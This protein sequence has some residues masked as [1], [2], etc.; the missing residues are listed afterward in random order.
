MASV[1]DRVEQV[2]ENISRVCQRVGRN[3]EEVTLVA[4]TK[5]V[6]PPAITEAIAA[7][8]KHIG[9]NR[10]QDAEQ[11]FTALGEDIRHVTRH[12]IGHLQT[13]KVKTAVEIF[14]VI[15]SVDSEKLLIEIEKRT[16][17]Q[18]RSSFD[19]LIEVNSGEEQKS[20]VAPVELNALLEKAAGCAHIQVKGLMTMAPLTDDKKQVRQAFRD[21]R[22]LR[23]KAAA[24]F[25]GHPRIDLHYLSMGMSSDYETAIEEGSNMVRIGSAI[26]RD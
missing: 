12:M 26:F 11:H 18:G 15:Q 20:G 9:E 13:N 17:G 8:I 16:A 19:I 25:Q 2:Q 1:K 21:L 6:D 5:Y 22:I 24:Q 23:D 10:V 7:G 3:P 14:D 4:V